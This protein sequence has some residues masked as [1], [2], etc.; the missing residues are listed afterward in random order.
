MGLPI[1]GL[2]LF[3]LQMRSSPTFFERC[4]NFFYIKTLGDLAWFNK[5]RVP[6][7]HKYTTNSPA[8]VGFLFLPISSLPFFS[9][10]SGSHQ[11]IVSFGWIPNR[12]SSHPREPENFGWTANFRA[13]PSLSAWLSD[14]NIF[15]REAWPLLTHLFIT[16]PRPFLSFSQP[17]HGLRRDIPRSP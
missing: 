7:R 3:R 17:H 8:S 10:S 11:T 16:S 1:L 15:A 12:V 13:C 6:Q 5:P 9:S 2:V 4:C 14:Q